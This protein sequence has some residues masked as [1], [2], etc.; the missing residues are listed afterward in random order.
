MESMDRLRGRRILVTGGM[1]FVGSHLVKALIEQN[2]TVIVLYRSF[3]PRSYFALQKLAQK[4]IIAIG[5]VKDSNRVT[6]I[7]TK[8]EIEDIFHLAAQPIVETAYYNPVETFGTNIIGTLNI[9]Q[10]A[11][12]GGTVRRIIITSSDKAYGKSSEEYT[13]N[14]SLKGD[15]PYEASKAAGDL[16]TQAYMKTYKAPAVVVRFGNIYGPGDLNLSRIIPSII[17]SVITGKTLRIRSD[18]TFVRDYIYI[19]DI[20]SAYL[21][22]LSQCDKVAGSVFNISSTISL[23][24]FELIKVVEKVFETKVSYSVENTQ[25]NEI[26][27]QHLNWN[28]IAR[29]G[30]KPRYELEKGLKETYMWYKNNSKFWLT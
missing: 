5:D 16:V 7:V 20:V 25:K 11:W 9:L 23:S 13:E 19:A 30:W 27:Y 10:A 22:L 17:K 1:G 14:H 2:A 12:V 6:D 8:Y 18:G 3:N 29:L 15:H 26:P 28:K 24:V 4:T 21:F